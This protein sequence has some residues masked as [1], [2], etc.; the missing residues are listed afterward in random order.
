MKSTLKLAMRNLLRY[1]RRT[2][3]TALLITL[4][5]VALLLFVAAAGSFKQTMVGSI[6]DSMLGHLQVHRKGYT[7]SMDNLP[8][9]MSLQPR[10]ALLIED[11]LKADPAVAAYSKR[12]KLG[13]MFSNFTENSSIRLNGIDAAAEDAAVPAL[14]QRISEGDKTGPLVEPGK[15]LVPALL[16]KGMKVKLGDQVVLV[17]TNASGSVNG[18]TFTVGGILEGITGPGGRDGYIDIKD[19][20]E[21]LRMDKEEVM[22]VAVRLKDIDQ[23]AAAQKRLTS[24]LDTIRNKEDK[25]ATELHTWAQLSPFANIVKMIDMM[26][27]FIRVMLVAI[28][29]VSV[30]NVMLMAVYERIREIG[31]LAAIGTQPNKLMAIFLSEGLLLGL[32]GAAAGVALSYA[33]VAALNVWPVVFNF[34]RE[35]ITL[36]PSLATG[37]VLGVLGLAVLVSGLASLQPAWRAA[38]MDPIQAL[39]HV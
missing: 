38:R 28:V 11:A 29:L 4:G 5:V 34:G 33:V 25:P 23:L 3:L 6:T 15:V 12:V 9:T 16:A 1:Q 19:A 13:A 36:H 24:A 26:T 35:Q 27:F 37:E 39:R 10:A 22:E 21:L 20:R 31:T 2:L 30:M 17:A 7:A 32:A 14:R 8:L 18:K